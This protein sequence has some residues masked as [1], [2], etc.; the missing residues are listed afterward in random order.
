MR[1]G[2][3]AAPPQ[4]R[5]D[6]GRAFPGPAAGPGLRR[7]GEGEAGARGRLTRSSPAAGRRPLSIAPAA[8]AAIFPPAPPSPSPP[9]PPPPIAGDAPPPARCHWPCGPGPCH[10]RP[11]H[12]LARKAGGGVRGASA[13]AA[14]PC[15]G[16]SL[17]GAPL[18]WT[19]GGVS[20]RKGR[21]DIGMHC[22][23][24]RWGHRPWK[25]EWEKSRR[26]TQCHGLVD[27][28]TFGRRLDSMIPRSFPTERILWFRS[29]RRVPLAGGAAARGPGRAGGA[30]DGQPGM[31]RREGKSLLA[32]V[33]RPRGRSSR[34]KNQRPGMCPP[35]HRGCAPPLLGPAL[36]RHTLQVK[37]T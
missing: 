33:W 4:G 17:A 32:N 7:E 16:S 3:A 19:S 14:A 2:G 22:P 5:C 36:A 8:T 30:G 24:R 18:G 21:L 15:A 35:R 29:A 20:A 23:R 27:T 10:A 6:L 34:K 28:L 31:P 11:C 37:L 9:P 26:G 12:W 1:G 13:V 25:G